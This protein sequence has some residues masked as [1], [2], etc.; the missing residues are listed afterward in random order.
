MPC[1]INGSSRT[2]KCLVTDVASCVEGRQKNHVVFVR[3]QFSVS[4]EGQHRIRKNFSG[5]QLDISELK[6]F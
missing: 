5:E 2:K 1:R 3:T 6:M 4:A